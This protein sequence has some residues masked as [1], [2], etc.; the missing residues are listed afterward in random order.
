E[1]APPEPPAPE[2]PQPGPVRGS[3]WER[4]VEKLRSHQANLHARADE[5]KNADWT[6][7]FNR[8]WE[9]LAPSP[10]PPVPT[11]GSTQR[12]DWSGKALRAEMRKLG[13]TSHKGTDASSLEP[14]PEAAERF[15]KLWER[16]RS[17]EPKTVSAQ[18]VQA[19]SAQ[20]VQAKG[21]QVQ[22]KG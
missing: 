2:R 15:N 14:N 21:Q 5:A 6:R 18:Q 12:P 17:P 9:K 22:A 13:K 4:A 19:K 7:Q 20:Q 8:A 11:I 3:A 1:P 16:L 10:R